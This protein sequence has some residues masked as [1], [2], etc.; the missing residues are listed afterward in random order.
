MNELHSQQIVHNIIQVVCEA[1]SAHAIKNSHLRESH[2]H[3]ESVSSS[4]SH[5]T[6]VI[7]QEF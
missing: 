2:V 5:S 7:E 6:I 4:V 1:C 3:D